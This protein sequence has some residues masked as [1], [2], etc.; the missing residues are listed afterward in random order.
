MKS[1]A[2]EQNDFFKLDA[3][4]FVNEKTN[5]IPFEECDYSENIKRRDELIE[6]WK[7]LSSEEKKIFKD[8]KNFFIEH[9]YENLPPA[10]KNYQI[11]SEE[12]L[13]RIIFDKDK[14]VLSLETLTNETDIFELLHSLEDVDKIKR[15]YKYQ[16]KTSTDGINN[17]V[18]EQVRNCFTQGREL[19][20]S[21][22][23]SSTSVKPLLYFYSLTAY[24]YGL[25]VLSNPI[26]YSLDTLTGHHGLDYVHDEYFIKLGGDVPYGTFTDLLLSFPTGYF[27]DSNN[28]HIIKN[29]FN[30]IKKIFEVGQKVTVGSLFGYMPELSSYLNDF[31][32][33][34]KMIFPVKIKNV[35]LG[36]SVGYE[37]IIG[38]GKIYLDEK[39]FDSLLNG[40]NEKIDGRLRYL[41]PQEIFLSL[42]LN[43]MQDIYG[44]FYLLD[45]PLEFSL[46][47]IAIHF[48][49][50]FAFSNI[51]RYDP[52]F[53]NKVLSNKINSDVSYL[54]YK[55]FAIYEKKLP[56]L[57]LRLINNVYPILKK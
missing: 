54:I 16:K 44:E 1:T 45:S 55:Y 46:P 25:I 30:S 18:A 11:F 39:K 27:L 13:K 38:D 36:T 32:G 2:F 14:K 12:I 15:I 50:M 7:N 17:E 3:L 48:M 19:F 22:K 51:Q 57:I 33:I 56:Y 40:N 43:I 5:R 41:I 4:G 42:N 8:L 10:Q 52:P 35:S 34:D 23:K 29:N 26:R 31:L 47:E 24:A 9:K 6:Q 49:I 28:T 20:E 53:W 37:L 21:G